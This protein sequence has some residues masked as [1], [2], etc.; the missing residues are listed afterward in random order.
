MSYAIT[1]SLDG[2]ICDRGGDFSWAEPSEDAHRFFNELTAS[3]GTFLWGRA[4]YET[5]KVWETM[6]VSA[7]EVP[8]YIAEFQELYRRAEKVV[9]STT[10][11]RADIPRARVLRSFDVAQIR[12]LKEDSPGDVGIGGAG[13]AA[14]AFR[15]GLIDRVDL[16][17][18]P[19]A[20]GG[21]T[22]ALPRDLRL[23]LDLH[24]TRRF[25]NGGVLLSYRVR[26]T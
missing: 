23:D 6:D 12:A 8:A 1:A 19:V 20:V 4:M 16:V 21:G 13:I 17:L 25:D 15:A 5:M 14:A 2:F 11:D 22:P 10:L 3:T 24:E 18:V 26:A 7:P 9:V